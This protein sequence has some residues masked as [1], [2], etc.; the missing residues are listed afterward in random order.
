MFAQ[1]FLKMDLKKT[2]NQLI[3]HLVKSSAIHI[4]VCLKK[5]LFLFINK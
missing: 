3:N 1:I 2:K 5:A 4:A